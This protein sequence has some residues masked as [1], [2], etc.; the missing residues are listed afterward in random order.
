MAVRKI[1]ADCGS[2]FRAKI[3]NEETGYTWHEGPYGSPGAAQGRITFWQ[4]YHRD[5]ET[6]E[7]PITGY[8]EI[9]FTQWQRF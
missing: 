9:A 7:T 4:N 3:T 1:D 2:I 5:P 8:P 6:G